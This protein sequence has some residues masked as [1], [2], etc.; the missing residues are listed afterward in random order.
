MDGEPQVVSQ[1]AGGPGQ[2]E[3]SLIYRTYYPRLMAYALSRLREREVAEDIVAEVFVRAFTHWGSLRDKGALEGWLFRIAHN[4]VVSHVR[5]R[6]KTCR[7]VWERGHGAGE[8]LEEAAV[9]QDELARM[10]AALARLPERYQRV[11]TLRFEAG[12]SHRQI[13]Q[14]LGLSEVNVRVI[15][16]RA[17]RRLRLLLEVGISAEGR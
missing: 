3:F 13:A 8:S 7:W 15:L 9:A 5:A 16:L 17:L 11:L 4:L 2:E 14:V 12:L 6:A 1:R 10:R